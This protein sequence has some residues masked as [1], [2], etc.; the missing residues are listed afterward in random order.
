MTVPNETPSPATLATGRHAAYQWLST[1]RHTI[2]DLLRV[3]PAVVLGKFLAVTS[4][5][6]GPLLLTDEQKSCGWVCRGEVAYSPRIESLNMVP[7]H[8]LYDEWYVFKAPAEL[9]TIR[10]GNIFDFPVSP[11]HLEVF[12]N[13]GFV[14]D[15]PEMEDLVSRFWQQLEWIRPEAYVAESDFGFLTFVARDSELFAQFAKLFRRD[16]ASHN[17]ENY[18]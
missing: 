16:P 4:C 5:D 1:T 2:D 18:T 15:A 11:R 12:V 7:L 3:S 9:G 10:D 17:Y 6:S 8:G 13:F 14:K